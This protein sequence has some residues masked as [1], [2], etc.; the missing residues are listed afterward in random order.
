MLIAS[1]TG[2]PTS[3]IEATLDEAADILKI[4]RATV[5]RMVS[6]GALQ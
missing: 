6:S 4:S 1:L 5:Y 2:R 3:Q